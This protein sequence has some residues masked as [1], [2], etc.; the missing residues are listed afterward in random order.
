MQTTSM[1]RL[2][3][4][5]VCVVAALGVPAG[6]TTPNPC[7]SPTT[8]AACLASFP[9][10]DQIASEIAA[11][12]TLKALPAT[13]PTLSYLSNPVTG[14]R[15][16]TMPTGRCNAIALM[17]NTSPPKVSDCTFGNATAPAARTLVLTGDSRAMMWATTLITIA[18]ESNWRIVVLVKPGCVAL[19]GSITQM[20]VKGQP[21]PWT[22]CDEFRTAVQADVKLLKPAVIVV[23][24]NPIAYFADGTTTVGNSALLASAATTYL[25]SLTTQSP[26][27]HM[28]LLSDFPNLLTNKVG[29]TSPVACLSAHR[30]DVH[31]CDGAPL[32]GRMDISNATYTKAAT[33]H[34]YTAISQLG[35]LCDTT[36]PAVIH[37]MIPYDREGLH[38]NST[39]SSWLTGVLWRSLVTASG[40]ALS[41]PS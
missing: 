14:S 38:I 10:A 41:L 35:W 34:G 40:D 5:A 11:A 28:V 39:Y 26:T 7:A 6:A 31:L 33:D 21:G 27:S 12:H 25:T 37:G 15:S 3:A 2:V 22:S 16:Y 36:C 29:F 19:A 4:A 9:T 32:S 1:K 23:V 13:T 20:N 30:A 17:G 24:S 8:A 18:S